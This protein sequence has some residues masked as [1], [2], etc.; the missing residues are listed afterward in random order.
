MWKE[1]ALA[2]AADRVAERFVL[3]LTPE[4]V[5]RLNRKGERVVG[6]L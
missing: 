3:E 4:G 2:L 1:R 5:T 6:R